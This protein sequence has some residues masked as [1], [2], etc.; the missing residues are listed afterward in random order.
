MIQKVLRN[1]DGQWKHQ[2]TIYNLQKN[3][4]NYYKNNI[5]IDISNINKKQ[6]SYT[7]QKINILKC[8]YTYQN[9]IY[10]ESLYFINPKFFISIALIKNNYKYIAISFNSYIKLS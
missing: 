3:T 1:I 9:I 5:K 2:Q 6:Y 8:K 10:N 7:K 4:K